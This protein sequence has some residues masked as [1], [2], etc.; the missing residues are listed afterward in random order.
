MT[1]N[2]RIEALAMHLEVLTGVHEDSE[3]TVAA[4]RAEV[5]GAVTDI[6]GAVPDI[7]DVTRRMGNIAAAHGIMLDD[8]ERRIQKLEE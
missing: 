2:E 4:N 5:R 3:N 8:P 1:I 6:R 7:R